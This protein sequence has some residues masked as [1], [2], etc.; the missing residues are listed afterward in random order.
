MS[1]AHKS[2]RGNAIFLCQ[3]IDENGAE[4]GEIIAA[5]SPFGGGIGS[6]VLVSSDGSATRAY[7]G[8]KH[9]PLRNSIVCVLDD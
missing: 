6:K 5:V 1:C 8:D 2:V 7:V 4:T 9:S 3:P